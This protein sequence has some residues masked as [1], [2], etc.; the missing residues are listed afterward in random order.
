MNFQEKLGKLKKEID[1]ELQK[2]L[3]QIVREIERQDEE[4]GRMM[5][6]MAK[7]IMA[8]GK[9]IRP[10]L[11]Y[12]GYVAAGG[13]NKKKI[14]KAGIG[15]ELI[16]NYFLVHDDIMDHGQKRHGIETVEEF[17]KK[18]NRDSFSDC[19]NWCHLGNS[20]AILAGDLLEVLGT[21]II[22]N[23]GFSAD[24]TNRAVFNLQMAVKNTIVGQVQD[25]CIE[26]QKQVS[27][28]EILSMYK[29]KTARYTIENPLRLGAI[30]AG[31][32]ETFLK[33]ISLFALPIG[34][35]FQI[36]DDILGLFEVSQKTGKDYGSDIKEGKKT[37]LVL[38]TFEK[39]EKKE[40]EFMQKKMGNEKISVKDINK[41]KN[42]V[43]VTG[44]L[45]YNQNLAKK[46]IEKGKKEIKKA[47]MAQEAKIFLLELAD[48]MIARNA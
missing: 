17:Y 18:I 44:A 42:I 9:R 40:N 43:Q 41:F 35:A 38:K 33:K 13:R 8:G 31:A 12:V 11:M 10:I 46:L 3:T 34:M 24:L 26:N 32:D 20:M 28:K 6:H 4:T 16:H 45:T 1:R 5:R 48:Y 36:Q 29:N 25:I 47:R 2:Y 19:K 22:L 30:L 27:E 7:I 21:Q 37:L 23:S 15:I 39:A 14:I